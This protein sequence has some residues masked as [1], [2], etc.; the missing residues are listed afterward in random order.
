MTML[1]GSN[2]L[3]STFREKHGNGS[4]PWKDLRDHP[5]L[6]ICEPSKRNCWTPASST[7][8]RG[9]ST[10]VKGAEPEELVSWKKHQQAAVRWYQ[11]CLSHCCWNQAE[12]VDQGTDLTAAP[13]IPQTPARPHGKASVSSH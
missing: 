3:S 1:M 13:T 11:S 5:L 2:S 9:N 4:Q 12:G 6:D 10:C 7:R 8:R